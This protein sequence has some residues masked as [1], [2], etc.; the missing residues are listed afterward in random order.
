MFGRARSR[1]YLGGNSARTGCLFPSCQYC[2]GGS[3]VSDGNRRGTELGSL[4]SKQFRI[5]TG[6]A[7]PDDLEAILIAPDHVEGLGADR[8]GGTQDDE[9]A[10]VHACHC[11]PRRE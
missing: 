4:A 3:L 6:S 10:P 11:L 7:Q 5:R 8:A 1:E 2:I 9:L